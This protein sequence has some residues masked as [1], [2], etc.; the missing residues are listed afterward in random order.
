MTEAQKTEPQKTEPQKTST[1]VERRDPATRKE[2]TKDRSGSSR[3][4]PLLQFIG[5]YALLIGIGATLVYFFPLV[6]DAWVS[7]SEA[8]TGA[9]I[10]LLRNT[11][12]AG[13][14]PESVWERS[15]ATLLITIG[16]L[17]LGLPVAWIYMYTRR[18]RFDPSLVQS[19]IIL[20]MVI[21]G[22]VI[23]V[24]NSVALAFGLAGIVAAVRFRNT[25]KDPKDAVYVFLA[26]GIGIASGVHALDI[27]LVMSFLFNTVVL[28]LWRFNLATIYTSELQRDL[29]SVGDRSLLLA[30]TARA[31]DA[32]KWRLGSEDSK[33]SDGILLVHTS[34]V[35]GAQRAVELLLAD[36]AKEWQVVDNLRRRRGITTFAVLL[37]LDKKGD[38]LELLS[39]L[40]ERWSAAISAAEYIP[41][42][43][44]STEKEG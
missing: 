3:E 42:R 38:P 31:R 23:I 16:A 32:L 10:D 11:V 43:R 44:H 2:P 34:D 26:I 27:A 24:K 7:T 41:L 12:P 15:T 19:V 21:A 18:L 40:D 20:P 33:D 29:L 8:P 9:T 30:E 1:E 5:F 28:L 35:E 39:E 14:G 37:Q 4:L 17:S 6:R 25:L 36:F 13:P 22:I